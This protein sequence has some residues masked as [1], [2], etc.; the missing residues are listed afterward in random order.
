M[1]RFTR[2]LSLGL[3]ARRLL[4]A[5]DR[6]TAA[7]EIQNQ[8]LARLVDRFAPEVPAA[9]AEDLRATG[10]SYTRDREQ[11]RILEFIGRM[12]QDVGREPTDEELLTY[13]DEQDR[14]S[15]ETA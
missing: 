7:I 1:N 3:I 10:V 5:L 2:A 15:R 6:Q 8:L 12:Q 9:S 13:L 11:A 14:T 4:R